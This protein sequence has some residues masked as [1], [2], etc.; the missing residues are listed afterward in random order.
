MRETQAACTG[1][2]EVLDKAGEVI[3]TVIACPEFAEAT[4][5]GRWRPKPEAPAP[6]QPAAPVQVPRTITRAQGKAALLK[7][8][9]LPAV[10]AYVESLPEGE[11]KAFARLALHETNEWYRDSAFLIAAAGQLGLSDEKLDELFRLAKS[12][13]L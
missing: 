1:V 8:G 9:L 11:D 6:L 13:E 12:I 4:W 7:A 2:I 5:P 3:N 10:E